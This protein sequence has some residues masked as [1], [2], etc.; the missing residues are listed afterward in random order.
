MAV[1]GVDLGGTRVS[2]ALFPGGTG[3]S[4]PLVRTDAALDEGDGRAVAKVVCGAVR[5]L[6]RRAARRGETVDA[7][8]ISVAGTV[9]PGGKVS[10]PGIPDFDEY[11][12]GRE[13]EAAVRRRCPVRL[14]PRPAACILAESWSGAAAGVRDAA[15]LE[16]GAGI[17]A[18][19][20]VD[21]ALLRGSGNLAGG[22]GWMALARPWLE[23]Y[24]LA[25]CFEFH[26]SGKGLGEVARLLLAATP[27][28][29]GPL[30]A[31]AP[32]ALT[33]EHVFAAL[34]LRDALAAEV[35]GDAV[36]YWGMAAANLVSLFNPQRIVFGG[37]VFGPALKLLS[38]VRGEAERWALPAAMRQVEFVAAALGDAAPLLGA[39]RLALAE[40]PAAAAEPPDDPA[41]DPAAAAARATRAGR[42]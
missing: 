2:A 24:R 20:L 7:V 15:Y 29:E 8:G 11:S 37:D 27:R 25:G 9:Q 13:V 39:A 18:G 42:P 17:G 6:A 16:V 41:A 31:V 19:I 32:D 26:A 21:G 14:V 3:D 34:E 4:D 36:A 5:E 22:I 12:L 35:L 38:R 40:A 33:S 28:Y 1:I 10:V 23:P 30:R